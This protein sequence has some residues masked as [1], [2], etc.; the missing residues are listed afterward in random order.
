MVWFFCL[1][2]SVGFCS[3][4]SLFP[5]KA[6]CRD[7]LNMSEAASCFYPELFLQHTPQQGGTPPCTQN[8]SPGESLGARFNPHCPVAAG[9]T[10]ERSSKEAREDKPGNRALLLA[11]PPWA[12]FPLHAWVDP[13]TSTTYSKAG[14]RRYASCPK[15]IPSP[16]TQLPSFPVVSV[17]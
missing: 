7:A 10:T 8:L 12:D 17:D 11:L 14:G 13:C 16:V 9:I 3:W 15:K 5:L 1:F 4:C 6:R 2:V